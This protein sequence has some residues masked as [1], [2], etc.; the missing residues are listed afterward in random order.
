MSRMTVPPR[1][2]VLLID[3]DEGV[4]KALQTR[5]ESMGMLCVTARTGAQ[6]VAEFDPDYVD[7]VVTDL[8]MP[9]L[10]GMG[11]IRRVREKSDVPI[12]VITGFREEYQHL[13][14][15]MENVLLCE[16]PFSVTNLIELIETELFFT[17]RAK[18]A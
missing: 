12:V 3:N 2:T 8:N 10:D 18:A 5:L 13:I 9:Q 6:G 16:K 4:L 1:A 11:V 14:Q 7:L 17:R 15:R